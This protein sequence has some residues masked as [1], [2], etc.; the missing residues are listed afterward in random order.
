MAYV[1]TPTA[2]SSAVQTLASIL[3]GEASTYA[4][5]VAVANVIQ[6]RAAYGDNEFSNYGND[7]ISQATVPNQFQGQSAPT[8][9]SLDIAQQAL[10]GTLPNT[11]PGPLNYAA[12]GSTASW[13][14]NA[15]NSG[16]GVTIG[17]NTFFLK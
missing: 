13:A 3:Q 12:P 14:V 15:L 8:P 4:G 6:N 16:D 5:Q 1:G 11:V 2:Y 17:G 7:L 10:D 9:Q